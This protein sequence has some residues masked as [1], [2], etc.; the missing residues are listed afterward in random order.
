MLVT[1]RNTMTGRE[2]I[3]E[4]AARRKIFRASDIEHELGLSRLYLWRLE[5]EGAVERVGY[6]LYSLADAELTQHQSI[7][8]VS[9]KIPEA[10][11]CLISALQFHGLTTQN[12]F[13]V[14]IAIPRGKR[15]PKRNGTRIR[16]FRSSTRAYENGIEKHLIDGVE[17]KVYSPAKTF[18]DCFAYQKTVGLDVCIEALRDAWRQRKVT[19]DELYHFAQIRNLKGTMQPYL[20]TLT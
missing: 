17:V 8:E 10:V 5:Q 20:N 15:Y 6:G 7:L 4:Y 9:V 2:K 11:I 13:A 1:F 14:W 12:P 18:A 19:M 16:V 3:L